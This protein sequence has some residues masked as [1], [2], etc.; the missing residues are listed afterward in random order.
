MDRVTEAAT[1][2]VVEFSDSK[3]TRYFIGKT[4]VGVL[5]SS[6]ILIV[7]S[8]YCESGFLFTLVHVFA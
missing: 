8:R 5:N 6:T 3:S 7:D 1:L 4:F 2:S